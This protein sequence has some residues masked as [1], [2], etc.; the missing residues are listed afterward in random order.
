MDSVPAST[1]VY[2]IGRKAPKKLI[3][4]ADFVNVIN[5]VKHPKKWNAVR[6]IEF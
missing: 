5:E 6:G 2:L 3:E 1:K 4:K